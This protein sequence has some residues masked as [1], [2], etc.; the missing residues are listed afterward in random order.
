MNLI[1]ELLKEVKRVGPDLTRVAIPAAFLEPRSLLEM[2]ADF[3]S[4]PSIFSA[5]SAGQTP[6][7]RMLAVCRW[8]FSAVSNRRGIKKPYNPILGERFDCDWDLGEGG[9]TRF[10]AE[11]V[12]HHPPRSAYYIE[13]STAGVYWNGDNCT[14][15]GFQ[16]TSASVK[17]DGLSIMWLP[18]H[19]E[20]YAMTFPD[21]YIRGLILGP[22]RFEMGTY[23]T[24]VSILCQ[25]SGLKATF[26]FI[27]KGMLFGDYD[28][29]SGTITYTDPSRAKSNPLYTISGKW[30]E[31]IVLED[32]KKVKSNL[33]VVGSVPKVRKN[34]KPADQLQP[35]ESQAVW[36]KVTV[37]LKAGDIDAANAGKREVEEGQRAERRVREE[38]GQAWVTRDFTHDESLGMWVYNHFHPNELMAASSATTSTAATLS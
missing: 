1:G 38:S 7:E 26:N 9:V 23:A 6:E 29:V 16:G 19:K 24:G 35:Y 11:Q 30:N 21:G 25:E 31:T 28:C 14:R 32:A 18:G 15:S 10:K 27:T 22:L 13:N 20:T 34:V 5:C 37:A 4:F 3:N 36:A 2:Y 33:F 17:N 8:Y 12:T